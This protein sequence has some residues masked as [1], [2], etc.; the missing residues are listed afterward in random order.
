MYAIPSLPTTG[1]ANR[2]NTSAIRASPDPDAKRWPQQL[3]LQEQRFQLLA[4]LQVGSVRAAG[5]IDR[6]V[7]EA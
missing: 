1:F 7:E 3:Q 2:T 6:V 4:Q 5:R